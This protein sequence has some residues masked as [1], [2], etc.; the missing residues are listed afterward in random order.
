MLK[1][2]KGLKYLVGLLLAFILFFIPATGVMAATSV[3]VYVNATPAFI[4]MTISPTYWTVNATGSGSIQISSTYYSRSANEMTAPSATVADGECLF[5]LT[6]TSTV[7]SDIT[8]NW[9]HFTGGDA[10][11]NGDG[12]AGANAFG[13]FSYWSGKLFAN[14]VIAKTAASAIAYNS[15]AAGV[16]TK[17]GLQLDTQTSAWTSGASTN[18]TGTVIISAH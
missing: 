4:S 16:N 1:K 15:L 17:F 9:S 7:V 18:S 11:Q 14:K 8:V 12:T 10:M 6:N 13:G 3:T 2:F 5:A